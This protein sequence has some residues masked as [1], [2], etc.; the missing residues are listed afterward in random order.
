LQKAFRI[1]DDDDSGKI[2]AEN[3]KKIAVEI[4]PGT[5]TDSEIE[6]MIRIADLNQ[7]GG[8]DY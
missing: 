2:T 7:D 3:L 6:E 5:V 1:F 8:V 4:Y